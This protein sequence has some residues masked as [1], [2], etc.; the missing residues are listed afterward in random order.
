MHSEIVSL[1]THRVF[2]IQAFYLSVVFYNAGIMFVKLSFLAMYYRAMKAPRWRRV[3]ALTS[4]LVFA[5]EVT[6]VFAAIFFCRPFPTNRD[7]T[8][9]HVKCIPYLPKWY[10]NTAGNI[11]LNTIILLLSIPMVRSM[12]LPRVQK[13]A[14]SAI[15]CL[16]LL[17][18]SPF[19]Y[20]FLFWRSYIVSL[21][22]S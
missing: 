13:L 2:A 15:F 11:I 18:V 3:V 1:T 8:S 22:I 4:V 5:W 10:Q 7:G 21:I 9:G 17:L 19:H 16:G 6:Q 20:P 14:L 12:K